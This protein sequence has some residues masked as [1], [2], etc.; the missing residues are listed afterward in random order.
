[1]KKSKTRGLV[2]HKWI[3][4]TQFIK[5]MKVMIFLLLIGLNNV[6]ANATYSQ[7]TTFTFSK[8]NITLRQLFEDIQKQ[9]EF[10]IF[11][12][13]SQVDLNWKVNVDAK[14]ASVEEILKQALEGAHLDFKVLDRQIVIFPAKAAY[15]PPKE[16]ERIVAD[17]PQGKTVSGTVTDDTGQ[18]LPGVAVVVKGT[19][20]GT[21]TNVNGEYTIPNIPENAVLLFSFVGMRAQEVVVGTQ[22]TINVQMVVDAIG[23][24]EVVAVGYGTQKK[25]NLTGSVT[26]INF[27]EQAESRPIIN[28]SS[29]LAGLSSGVT[30][31]QNV[32]NPGRDGASIRIRGLGTL[33]N[34]DPLIIIDGMEG[35]L[36]AINPNDIESISILKD[37]A[38]SAIY[39]SR[40]AN[41]VI[42][43]TSK[44]GTKGMININ[45][46]GNV[47]VSSPTNLLHFVS[48]YPTYMRLINESARNID[49][50]EPFNQATIDTW[51]EAN[52]NPNE[53]NENGV[54]NWVAFPNTD[55]AKEMYQSNIVQEHALSVTGGNDK[56]TFLFSGAYLD[57]PGLVERTAIK[58][59]NMR[60]NLET[61]INNWLTVGTR[62]YALTQDKEL[63]DYSSVLNYIR[64]STPG[65]IPRYEG[66]YGFPE[67]PEESPNA[68]NLYSWLNFT[69]GNDRSSRFN[70]TLYSKVTFMPGLSWD[71]N[72][73]YIRRFDEYNSHESDDGQIKFST[74]ELMRPKTD[75]S[76]L[77]TYRRTYANQSYTLEN[78]LRYET[79]IADSHDINALLGYN[80]QY[81][82]EY[83]HSGTKKG[84]IDQSITTL[85]SA[86]EMVSINGDALD[87]SI[88]SFFGRL[89]YGF[90][91]RYLFEANFRYDGSSHFHPDARWGIFPSF[92][93]AW[94][95]SEEEF[96]QDIGFVKNLKIRASWGQLGNNATMRGGS[97]D[98]YAYQS[99]YGS[100]DYSFGGVQIAGLRPTTIANRNLRWESTTI[101]NLGLDATLLNDR[102]TAEFDFYNKLTDG[103]L[104][105]PPIYLTL[106]V[107]GAPIRNTAEVLNKGLEVT[108]GW[109]D[110]IGDFSYS[111]TGN[112]AYNQNKVTKYK[113][114]LI[115]EWR[116]NDA[117]TEVYYSNLGDVSSGGST[118]VLEGYIMNEYY[119]LD[120]YKGTGTHFNTDGSVNITGGPTDGMI[121]TPQDME[122]LTA[123]VDAGYNFLP[124]Q[125]IRKNGIW[126]GDYIYA[127]NNNDGIY[128]NA[129]DNEFT[130]KSSMPKISFGSQINLKWKNFD[131]GMVWSGYAGYHLF[132]LENNY[133]RANT[134]L[135]YQ[136]GKMLENDHY[137]FNEDDP[138]DLYNNIAASN[139]RLR[140]SGLDPQNTQSSTRYLYDAKYVKLK[141][142]TFGYTIPKK[143]T[144]RVR[145]SKVK[146]YFSGENLL[147]ITSFPGLDPE[148]GANTNYPIMRQFAFGTNITF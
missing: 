21:V 22:N 141:N 107:I 46:N 121:R 34:N 71:F 125:K 108:L 54:P 136:I 17:Q 4:G 95:I 1:M 143:I 66:K 113:G 148:M 29:T 98:H 80:E 36:D 47:S 14:K 87:N 64:Q 55:W 84:L 97:F 119:M 37:A 138:N 123:M 112:F 51:I 10:N 147:T 77:M 23:I 131:M 32:G 116:T 142:L 135:G 110:R 45:Y 134:S 104:T 90:K 3:G 109:R 111:V 105:S 114:K 93:G 58:R 85:S 41:G 103:I 126:Y 137:Y 65:L 44:K 50:T 144:D 72:Y 68:N 20:Q 73:N 6:F 49:V 26:S 99:V 124:N 19:T 122:W 115:R 59:Y 96:M 9:S 63:G 92:S 75:P 81:Y 28:V 118:R 38:A 117:G 42:L 30:V 129:F 76:Q 48:D 39:G 60:I 25:V 91:Q 100:A 27:T 133:N 53:L 88:R 13:D 62:M 102:L 18:P 145:I 52:K 8:K 82:Y 128:G 33:N 56:S 35:V 83:D 12:K 101:T 140:F 79:T 43:V 7:S 74:G 120:V 31:R 106:G 16:I 61:N 89:N 15:I 139:P 11:Y 127:D 86:T 94:R 57:N 2:F 67:A 24:D 70:T 5:I 40:A 132:W 130:G 78:L 146:L 69:L